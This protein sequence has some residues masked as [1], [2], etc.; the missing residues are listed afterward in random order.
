MD[1]H[2]PSGLAMT[3]L[4]CYREGRGPVAICPLELARPPIKP[5]CPGCHT[6]QPAFASLRSGT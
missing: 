4:G 2:G 1:C 3:E 6:A 5:H